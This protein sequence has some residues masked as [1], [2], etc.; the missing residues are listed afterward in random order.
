MTDSKLSKLWTPASELKPPTR[1]SIDLWG[2]GGSGKTH[3]IVFTCPG[4]ILLVNF[5]RDPSAL[6]LK[7]GRKDIFLCNLHTEGLV[8]S[9]KEAEELVRQLFDKTPYVK[10][11]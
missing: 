4:P 5:D 9:D 11:G 8:L 7:S 3:C 6:I 1:W 10:S 2:G